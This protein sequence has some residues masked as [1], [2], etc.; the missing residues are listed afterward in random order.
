MLCDLIC[1]CVIFNLRYF[2]L[3]AIKTQYIVWALR[4][5]LGLQIHKTIF[6]RIESCIT[7]RLWLY[8]W[9]FGRMQAASWEFWEEV[10][11]AVVVRSVLNYGIFR[12]SMISTKF[13]C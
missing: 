3:P 13:V 1:V 9:S 4:F 7:I 11:N 6:S 2:C 8:L 5:R 10:I 12:F